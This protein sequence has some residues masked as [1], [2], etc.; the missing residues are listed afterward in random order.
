MSRLF[1]A[2]AFAGLV[3][4]MSG[5]A[6]APEASVATPAS[7][8]VQ[9]IYTLQSPRLLEA[10]GLAASRREPGLYWSHND[11]GGAPELFALT[12]DGKARGITRVVGAAADDWEDIASA[13]CPP[14]STNPACLYVADIGDNRRRRAFVTVLIVEEPEVGA[15]QIAPLMRARF[16]Y[17]DGPHNAEALAVHPVNGTLYIITKHGFSPEGIKVFKANPPFSNTLTTLEPVNSIPSRAIGDTTLGTITAAD[18]T[19]DGSRLVMRD[20]RRGYVLDIL[21]NET[22]PDAIFAQTPQAFDLPSMNIAEALAVTPDGQSV[23]VTSEGKGAPIATV[24]LPPRP[25]R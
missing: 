20:Y 13:P 9:L 11:S 14:P 22:N 3:L 10:S 19:P 2:A 8:Q 6:F 25:A 7:Q 23:V 1:G 4:A 24:H 18:F 17:P 12:A 15:A 21:P 16:R 5:P